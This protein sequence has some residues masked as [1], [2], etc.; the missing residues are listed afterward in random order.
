MI[1]LSNI[2]SVSLGNNE[3]DLSSVLGGMDLGEGSFQQASDIRF[4]H[5]E[6][7][8]V[9]TKGISATKLQWVSESGLITLVWICFPWWILR[10]VKVFGSPSST[11]CFCH[12]L[13]TLCYVFCQIKFRGILPWVAEMWTRDFST[14]NFHRSSKTGFISSSYFSCWFVQMCWFYYHPKLILQHS[15]EFAWWCIQELLRHLS[16][17]KPNKSK[18]DWGHL[19]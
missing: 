4:K 6:I 17:S 9:E 1:K 16:C 12:F 8:E 15:V 11:I 5:F 10:A 14:E 13:V 3:C 19:C 7:F 18:R 2:W